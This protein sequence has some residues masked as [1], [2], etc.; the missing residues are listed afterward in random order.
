MKE[1]LHVLAI[2]LIFLL[3][4]C[5]IGSMQTPHGMVTG[6]VTDA[7]TGEPLE[8]VNVY[9]SYTT[10]GAS[11]D[12]AGRYSLATS[13]VGVFDLIASRVGFG[14]YARRITLRPG[15]TIRIDISLTPS[16]IET[17]PVEVVSTPDPEW[18]RNLQLFRRAFI[19]HSAFSDRCDILNPA[20]L[21]FEVSGDTLFARSDSIV[22]VENRALG[23]LVYIVIA[24]FVWNTALDFG[25]F[26]IY[27]RFT[28]LQSTDPD[29][30][31]SWSANRE[32]AFRGSVRH[33][34]RSLILRQTTD[35][36][37]SI[38]SGPLMKIMKTEGHMVTDADFQ[39]EPADGLPFSTVKFPG[40]IRVEYGERDLDL[41]MSTDGYYRRR[42]LEKI[43]SRPREVSILRL[44]GPPALVDSAGNLFDPL[45]VEVAGYWGEHRI[46]NL[47]PND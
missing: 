43:S 9:L 5:M 29:D 17:R 13:R 14:G 20:V 10:T 47:L 7:G 38:S 22:I 25:H 28:Q 16:L 32:T 37:F 36:L 21:E 19:G 24:E 34:L 26:L 39:V 2:L 11:T 23:Y 35:E 8:N 41:S 30:S 12:S 33:F 18:A 44:T 42:F 3:P 1:V 15:D 46:E 27:P 31:L 40:Y 45:S 6:R 4:E